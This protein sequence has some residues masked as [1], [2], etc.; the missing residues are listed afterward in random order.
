MLSSL[1]FLAAVLASFGSIILPIA[2]VVVM[3]RQKKADPRDIT[4]IGQL[5]SV[6]KPLDPEGTVLVCGELWH[7]RVRTEAC[8]ASGH[9]NVR[10]VGARG[11]LLE[12]EPA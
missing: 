6:E 5:A 9:L 7:A 10:V 1:I 3:S 4:L 12:V 8:V 11:H 2:I